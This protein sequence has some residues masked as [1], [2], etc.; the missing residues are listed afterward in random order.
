LNVRKDCGAYLTGSNA[1]ILSAELAAILY[2]LIKTLP[3]RERVDA[4]G[5]RSDLIGSMEPANRV[6][7]AVSANGRKISVHTVE[8]QLERADRELHLA[9]SGAVEVDFIAIGELGEEY[10]QVAYT[11]ESGKLEGSWRHWKS[12]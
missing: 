4:L 1:H 10:C 9:Q 2:L 7:N 12:S 3:L 11:V 8:N 5:G 6:A